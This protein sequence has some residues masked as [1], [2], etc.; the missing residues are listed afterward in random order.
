MSIVFGA[1]SLALQPRL[2]V[3]GRP[4]LVV[5]AQSWL[6]DPEFRFDLTD[7]QAQR[8]ELRIKVRRNGQVFDGSAWR[9]GRRHWVRCR[10]S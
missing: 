5:V 10:E 4:V 6:E 7:P 3:S 9:N 8:R 1:M 2:T